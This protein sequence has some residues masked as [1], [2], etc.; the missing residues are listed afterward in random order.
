MV[1]SMNSSVDLVMKATS[2]VSLSSYGNVMVGDKAFEYYNERNVRDYIQ[3]PWSEISYIAA[4]VLFGGRVINR[5]AVFVK[6]G[7]H[8]SFS[9]RDNKKLL[10]AIRRYIPPERMRKSETF[11][12][13]VLRG[14]KALFGKKGR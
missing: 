2:F 12:S 6:S 11:F 3:I 5:F 13:V 14:L 1:K 4:S 10:R 9:A 8:F 7:R